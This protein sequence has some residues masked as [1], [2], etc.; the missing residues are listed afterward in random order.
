MRLD[1]W[2][3][4][5]H[6]AAHIA[7]IWLALPPQI[8]G[9]WCCPRPLAA[10]VEALG[11]PPSALTFAP[12]ARDGGPVIVASGQ[13]VRRVFPRPAVMVNHGAGQTYV[14]TD[15]SSYS[16]GRNRANV[17]LNICPGPRDV[18]TVRA[19]QPDVP[20]VAAGCAYLDPWHAGDRPAGS[21]RDVVAVS[22]HANIAV[23][24]ETRTAMW[25]Y[26][27]AV[28]RLTGR[29]EILG[30][31]HPRLWRQAEPIWRALKVEPVRSWPEVLDRADVYAVDNSSTA[32]EFASTGRPVLLLNAPWYRRD[33]HH[34][35][36]FWDLPP[37][38]TCDTPDDLDVAVARTLDDPPEAQR[39][40]KAACDHVYAP[41]D[42]Q[43]ARRAADAIA[44]TFGA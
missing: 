36:R 12:P 18:T 6:Y 40:R 9:R 37:G 30:H 10:D 28:G 7:P 1:V 3:S 33:V 22:F 38:L 2:T 27:E 16:G 29:H 8:R 24:P 42:G 17:R 35:L 32:Y 23:V 34:G 14:G 15:S 31:A 39:L 43:A 44:A 13:D 20:A 21:G 4:E 41:A 19:A 11:V 25:H 26:A 5:R